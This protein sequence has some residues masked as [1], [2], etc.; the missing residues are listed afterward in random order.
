ME[1]ND[2]TCV[3]CGISL[4]RGR[5][6]M[7]NDC[8]HNPNPHTCD[9]C[10]FFTDCL[11]DLI[12]HAK[13]THDEIIDP[14]HKCKKLHTCAKHISDHEEVGRKLRRQ[15]PEVRA[16]EN[17]SKKLKRMKRKA[18]GDV[19]EIAKSRVMT[20]TRDQTEERK[21]YKRQKLDTATINYEIDATRKQQKCKR[22]TMAH[23]ISMRKNWKYVNTIAMRRYWKDNHRRYR[24]R[25]N[26][27][28]LEYR[29]GSKD[30]KLKQIK[31]ACDRVK[32]EF[33]LSDEFAMRLF[34]QPC[35][36]C[37]ESP[38][39]SSKCKLSGIDRV[40]NDVTYIE[41]NVVPCCP[42]CNYM[43]KAIK[44]DNFIAYC[45]TINANMQSDKEP[46]EIIE[47]LRDQTLQGL[48]HSMKLIIGL[49]D[50]MRTIDAIFNPNT[51]ADKAQKNKLM[52]EDDLLPD[53][54]TDSTS[55]MF[56]PSE[57]NKEELAQQLNEELGN[58]HECYKKRA[59]A[60]YMVKYNKKYEWK[61]T[62]EEAVALVA[63]GI[64][65][66]CGVPY[67]N[68]LTLDR[69]D[70]SGDYTMENV[71]PACLTCNVMKHDLTVEDFLNK[72]SM[73]AARFDKNDVMLQIETL[74]REAN[75][76]VKSQVK[77]KYD[78]KPP[79]KCLSKKF[80]VDD[81]VIVDLETDLKVYHSKQHSSPPAEYVYC[82]M[83]DLKEAF[84]DIRPCCKCV[85][86]EAD[87]QKMHRIYANGDVPA[88]VYKSLTVEMIENMAHP[89]TFCDKDTLQSRSMNNDKVRRNKLNERKIKS[90]GCGLIGKDKPGET[91]LLYI[92]RKP[93]T[94]HTK[95]HNIRGDN[96]Q[97]NISKWIGVSLDSLGPSVKPCK[98]CCDV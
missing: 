36:Y 47:N 72:V 92:N 26:Q 62:I 19:E 78:A 88:T 54:P 45:I 73:I 52:M 83:E 39:T 20:N 41:T 75:L 90:R 7:H 38:E 56:D 4:K 84:P 95:R 22:E 31:N 55:G 21:K 44:V 35:F 25:R 68:S 93:K 16:K 61:L 15:N 24:L 94:Y 74:K 82:C 33:K 10:D 50:K 71:V 23:T 57:A 43:K 34:E 28:A 46:K 98:V 17:A 40:D 51:G 59:R 6:T 65:S 60:A 76:P 97:A 67:K 69:L 42:T 53:I 11:G 79:A 14:P 2:T 64:C 63:N 1:K 77:R 49:Y 85:A 37:G 66:Y 89:I 29:V 9:G 32:R 18:D 27:A 48:D 13:H 58:I 91:V 30:L 86:S 12:F 8:V 81:L 96:E 5:V 70:S 3:K 80:M 87:I